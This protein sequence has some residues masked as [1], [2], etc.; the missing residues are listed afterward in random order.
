MSMYIRVKRN[1]TTYFI[2]C[3][4]TEKIL[5]IKQ[6]LNVLID[7][8]VND[9]QLILFAT[10]EVLEDSKSLAEQK[11]ENDTIVALT[12]RKDGNEFEEVNIEQLNDFYQSRD[13]DA[14]NW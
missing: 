12:L 3:D 1:K 4:P 9:Q 2:Q 14:G 7:Q 13:T 11:V 10:G 5:G 8:P 6:K